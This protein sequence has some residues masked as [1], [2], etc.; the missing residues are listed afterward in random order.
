VLQI[1]FLNLEEADIASVQENLK[2]TLGTA[3]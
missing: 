3:A 1:R 2:R